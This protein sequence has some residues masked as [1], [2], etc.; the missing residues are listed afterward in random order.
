MVVERIA[1]VS[2][3]SL[4]PGPD[5]VVDEIVPFYVQYQDV[6]KVPVSLSGQEIDQET[7]LLIQQTCS[8][9]PKTAAPNISDFV[10][11]FE[12]LLLAGFTEIL[13]LTVPESFSSTY[14]NAVFAGREI[15][16]N[17]TNTRVRVIDTGTTV[18]GV[19]V[20]A[21]EAFRLREQHELFEHIIHRL[22]ML[23]RKIEI[24]VAFDTLK[25]VS[26]S[27][28]VSELHA[29]NRAETAKKYARG[30]VAKLV[31]LAHHSP[32]MLL[33]IRQG[34]ENILGFSLDF[35]NCINRM[36]RQIEEREFAREIR[37]CYLYQSQ[38]E[39]EI[40]KIYRRFSCHEPNNG[41][42]NVIEEKETPLALLS[43]TGPKFIASVCVYE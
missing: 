24:F 12:R 2:D 9:P 20:L 13:V 27:G 6:N 8:S 16:K 37:Q 7:F 36:N 5:Q 29:H 42:V 17:H 38:A 3:G 25:Y 43:I 4:L 14:N 18:A 28:R 1:L 21:E 34:Q 11:C 19:K 23:R 40:D 31:T 26:A 30:L 22:E 15:E 32:K 41:F 33:S 10:Q 39:N 35:G